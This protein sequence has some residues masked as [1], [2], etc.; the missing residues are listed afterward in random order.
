MRLMASFFLLLFLNLTLL[1]QEVQTVAFYNVENL[2]DSKDD[3]KT[4]DD[5]YTPEGRNHWTSTLVNQKIEH[6]AQV[7]SSI[8]KKETKR[9]PLLIGL[10]EVENRALLE[11]LIAHPKLRAY[12]YEIIH[13]DSPDYRGIDVGLLYQKEFFFL[14]NFKTYRLTLINPKTQN[15][16]STR[17][18]LV[19]SGYWENEALTVL[20]NHWPSRRGGQKR[21]EAS[22]M[23]AA[24]LQQRIIDSLQR[25]EPKRT[26]ISMGDFNDNP[27]NKS[28]RY[29]IK[30]NSYKPHF[31]P[32]YNPMQ[33]LF[34]K[35]I[36]SLAY[37]DRWHLFDQILV[38]QELLNREGIILLKTAV[39]NPPYLKNPDGKYKG[40]PYRNTIQGTQLKGY[41][42][43]FPVYIVLGKGILN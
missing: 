19:V 22:R 4:F 36:G 6:L 24:R 5:D 25:L 15:R 21:S 35:G 27:N 39:F 31:Q 42:D 43:H 2:F 13:F 33:Q 3:P 30:E 20:V 8:G 14:E 34:K 10:A 18:Q 29:L 26:L 17:D 12:G 41:S 9:P 1:S 7:L 16:S 37:R 38:D 11:R 28:I 32:L 40:Y 23:A